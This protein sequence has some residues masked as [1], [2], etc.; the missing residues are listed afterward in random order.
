M[1]TVLIQNYLY[2]NAKKYKSDE[3]NRGKF[4]SGNK[5]LNWKLFNYFNKI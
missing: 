3:K 5:F 4:G 1:E 2:S